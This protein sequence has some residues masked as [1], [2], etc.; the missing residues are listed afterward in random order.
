[1]VI[2]ANL[3]NTT[4]YIKITVMYTV[5]TCLI[6][7]DYAYEFYFSGIN[8]EFIGMKIINMDYGK[9]YERIIANIETR[10]NP[11]AYNKKKKRILLN[12]FIL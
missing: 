8:I 9:L 5:I 12:S 4:T 10:E 6:F 7:L 1:M 11:N 3:V 2:H